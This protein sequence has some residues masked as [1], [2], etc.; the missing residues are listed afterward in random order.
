MARE[1]DFFARQEGSEERDM[2]GLVLESNNAR[3]TK[4]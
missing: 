3:T 2:Q 1:A 4:L